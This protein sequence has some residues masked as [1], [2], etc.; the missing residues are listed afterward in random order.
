MRKQLNEKQHTIIVAE[1]DASD[2][3]A[4]KNNDFSKLVSIIKNFNFVGGG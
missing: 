4:F 2:E 1:Y 3:K